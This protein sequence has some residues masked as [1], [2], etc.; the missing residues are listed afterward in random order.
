M[1]WTNS[2]VWQ[3][4]MFLRAQHFQQLNRWMEA[5]LRARTAAL[6][7]YWWGFTEL[8]VDQTRLESGSFALVS[9]SGVFIDGTPFAIPFDTDNPPSLPV[10]EKARG[11]LVYLCVA[12]P[13]LDSAQVAHNGNAASGR[14][15]VR[16]FSAIDTF[17][18]EPGDPSDPAPLLIGRLQLRFML[19]ADDRR[20]WQCLPVARIADVGTNHRVTLDEEWIPPVVRVDA[21]K[22]L[23][24]FITDIR[25]KLAEKAERL[26]PRLPVLQTPAHVAEL[27]FLQAVNRWLNLLSH[28]TNSASLHPE[29][30]YSAFVQMAGEFGTFSEPGRRLGDYPAYLHDDLHLSFTRLTADLRRALS[31]EGE[32]RAMRIDL[33]QKGN[34]FRG[35]I[36]QRNLLNPGAAGFYLVVKSNGPSDMLRREFPGQVAIGDVSQLQALVHAAIPGIAVSPMPMNPPELT[37]QQAAV[38]FELERSSR[39]WDQIRTSSRIGLHVTD[40]FPGISLELWAVRA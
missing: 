14:Y 20:G 19:E 39:Y 37:Y 32:S 34:W 17:P 36:F 29:T 3:E 15:Q 35:Q 1:S 40:M 11:S 38:Y 30:V 9:A 22:R 28:W 2:V 27:M 26:A 8:S 7:P 5:Q 24:S 18:N 16:S 23:V 4:G 25:N 13:S 31:F 12:A 10:D 6:G 21:H 33:E